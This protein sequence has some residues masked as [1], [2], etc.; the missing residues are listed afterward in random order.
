MNA[1]LLLLV[2]LLP[3]FADVVDATKPNFIVINID[4]LGY[5]DIGPFGS[6]QNRT[7]NLD[8]MAAEGRKLTSHYAAPVCSPSRAA[9]LTGC[10]PKRVLPIPW[11]LFPA[12]AI[13]LNPDEET[14]AELLKKAG[15]AT[16]CV[17]KWHLGDQPEFLPTQQGFDSYDGIPYSNDMGPA[18]DGSKSNPGQP[19]PRRKANAQAPDNDETGLRGFDQPPL[20]FLHNERVAAR[21]RAAEQSTLT[22]LHRESRAVHS[23]AE[24]SSLLPLLG[25]R[26]GSFSSLSGAEF[27]GKSHHGLL[28]D[29]VEEMD[30]SVGRVLDTVRTLNLAARTLVIFTSDNGGPVDAGRSQSAAAR[31]ERPDVRGRHP[32]LHH[33]LVAGKNSRR[34]QHC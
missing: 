32:N 9:L 10:Y 5:A 29:W 14:I 27:R 20:P 24:G 6:Q 25:T 18:E 28:S 3:G 2:S 17:G 33:R 12:A 22:R 31:H 4:D 21:V 23:R 13:G 30:W 34:H 1:S 19:V 15:Y 7:P 16:A 8:R 11:V 26:G